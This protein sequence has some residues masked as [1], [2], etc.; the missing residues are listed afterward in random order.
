MKTIPHNIAAVPLAAPYTREGGA[1]AASGLRGKVA[2]V[3]GAA[4]GLGRR[5]VAALAEQGALVVATDIRH[6]VHELARP[7]R[8][9][10][11]AADAA[12]EVGARQA[13]ALAL[14]QFGRLD[15]LVNTAV[16][17]LDKSLLDTSVGEWDDLME[18]NARGYFVQAREA[19][20]RMTGPGAIVNVL[21]PGGRG[22]GAAPSCN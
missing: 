20:R 21:P 13:A 5:I 12:D 9:L 14:A 19:L 10:A 16:G 4:S 7:R 6:S 2:I 15:I 8:I 18:L 11:L 17:V 22:G 3:T 1:G